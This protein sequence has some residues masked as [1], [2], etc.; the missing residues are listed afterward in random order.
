MELVLSSIRPVEKSRS[1]NAHKYHARLDVSHTFRSCMIRN[2]AFAP[3]PNWYNLATSVLHN[4][5]HQLAGCCDEGPSKLPS[6]RK[7]TLTD[8]QLLQQ[9]HIIKHQG[10]GAES[11]A[12]HRCKYYMHIYSNFLPKHWMQTFKAMKN[13]APMEISWDRNFYPS[14]STCKRWKM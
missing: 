3:K 2:C 8:H 9:R 13:R 6:I 7:L 12:E 1:L 14:I 10:A 5:H 11:L 4:A